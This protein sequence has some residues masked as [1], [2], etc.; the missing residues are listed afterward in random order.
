MIKVVVA[1]AV[2]KMGQE[3][4]KAVAQAEGMQLVGAV[5]SR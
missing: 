5:D 1:G 3:S 4:C 2:G